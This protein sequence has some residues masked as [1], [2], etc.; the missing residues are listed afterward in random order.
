MF[1][2]ESGVW[3]YANIFA[4]LGIFFICLFGNILTLSALCLNSSVRELKSSIFVGNLAISDLL[5]GGIGIPLMLYNIITDE[6][7]R[8]LILCNYVNV[9]VLYHL[10]CIYI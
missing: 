3:F 8:Y 6:W 2:I 7:V 4:H 10:I 9:N 1:D 5:C